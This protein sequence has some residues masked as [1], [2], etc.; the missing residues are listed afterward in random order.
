MKKS[1]V[2]VHFGMTLLLSLLSGCGIYNSGFECKPG[3]GVGCVSS[4]EVNDMILEKEAK[5]PEPFDQTEYIFDP[6]HPNKRKEK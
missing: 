4:W 5:D 1:K 6:E 3:K 2:S